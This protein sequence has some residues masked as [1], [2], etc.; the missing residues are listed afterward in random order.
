[1]A[2]PRH[3]CTA[4]TTNQ[5]PFGIPGAQALMCGLTSSA[6]PTVLPCVSQGRFFAGRSVR[7]SFFPEE[8]F[9][10]TDLAPK[11]GEFD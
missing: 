2:A 6:L 11:Q 3:A 7:V 8:R 4:T 10:S 1:M 9:T 5:T